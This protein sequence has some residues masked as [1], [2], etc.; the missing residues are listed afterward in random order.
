MIEVK[1]GGVCLKLKKAI[2][3]EHI[4]EATAWLKDCAQK[5]H[6]DHLKR[7]DEAMKNLTGNLKIEQPT[8]QE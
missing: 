6:E 3:E 4:E 5:I 7:I 2:A 8:P 1:H